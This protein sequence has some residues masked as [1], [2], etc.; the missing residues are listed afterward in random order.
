M[1]VD[2]GVPLV[3]EIPAKKSPFSSVCVFC[4]SSTGKKQS[5]QDAAV[6]LGAELV[7]NGWKTTRP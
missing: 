2:E 3:G 4:G 7:S 6:E 1:E 5:Y